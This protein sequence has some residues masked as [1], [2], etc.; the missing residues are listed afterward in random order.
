M[1][2]GKVLVYT[3]S[4]ASTSQQVER[5]FNSL[6]K[7]QRT[8]GLKGGYD[9]VLYANSS[10]MLEASKLLW[11]NGPVMGSGE[12]AG[13]HVA[14]QEILAYAKAND[15]KFIVKVDDD[16]EWQTPKWLYK[17]LR[18]QSALKR[19]GDK[20]SNDTGKWCVLAPRVKGLSNPIPALTSIKVPTDVGAIPLHVVNIL[21]GACRLHHISFFDDYVVDVRRA[22]GAG[23]DTSIAEHASAIG[24]PMFVS[25]WVSVRHQTAAM[26]EADPAYFRQ[27]AI[28]QRL[29]FIPIWRPPA[30]E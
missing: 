2:S 16:L 18:V 8:C 11:L 20:I 5:A 21:G 26:E 14:L 12:N 13:Q 4:R 7:G 24:I 15:Y 3:V 6:L 28:F 9:W 29:P 25:Y 30:N 17:L 27:H 10:K 23:G 22:L 1:A 19:F